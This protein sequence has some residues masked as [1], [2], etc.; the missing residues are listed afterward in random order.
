MKCAHAGQPHARE[1]TWRTVPYAT[2]CARR[3]QGSLQKLTQISLSLPLLPHALAG[4]TVWQIKAIIA[5]IGWYRLSLAVKHDTYSHP[6]LK[7]PHSILL[8]TAGSI[9]DLSLT[10]NNQC[11]KYKV[12]QVL[13]KSKDSPTQAR[14]HPVTTFENKVALTPSAPSIL[15][16]LT[17][18]LASQK[19]AV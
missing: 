5:V 1:V 8:V 12:P 11:R 13:A 14:Q 6:V 4:N 7:S 9:P 18:D 17:H 16:W 2:L 10:K 19:A 3:P 15:G